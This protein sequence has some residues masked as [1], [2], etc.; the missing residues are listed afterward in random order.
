MDVDSTA[1]LF[2]EEH[3][4][5]LH[6][7]SAIRY[8]VFNNDKNYSGSQPSIVDAPLLGPYLELLANGLDQ[9]KG[10]I[11]VPLGKAGGSVFRHL[12]DQ[13]SLA[14][15]RCLFGFPHPSGAF[16]GRAAQYEANRQQLTAKVTS[17]FDA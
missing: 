16:A 1:E 15:G 13:S 4:V 11:V 10:A 8:P 9:V 2:T 5:L 14:E 3:E 6:S 12:I 7:T 17:W